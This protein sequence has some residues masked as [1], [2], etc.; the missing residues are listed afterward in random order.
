[1]KI[2]ITLLISLLLTTNSFSQDNTG[3]YIAPGFNAVDDDGDAFENIFKVKTNWIVVPMPSSFTVG[4][5]MNSYLSLEFSEHLN[6]YNTGDLKD[7]DTVVTPVLFLAMDIFGK[8]HFNSLYSKMQWLDPFVCVGM[9]ATLRG[10]ELAA[11]PGLGFGVSFWFTD[12]LGLNLQS[13]AKFNVLS[14]N[15]SSYLIH[16][17]DFRIRVKG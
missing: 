11:M 6:S 5:K 9:G 14:K 8:Y 13:V 4:K 7:H 10:S 3:W 15:S 12:R 2:I 16:S 1:M 17:I